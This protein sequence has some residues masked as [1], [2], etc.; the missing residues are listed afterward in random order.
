MC[1]RVDKGALRILLDDHE[2]TSKALLA[3]NDEINIHTQNLTTSGGI[4]SDD[5]T[6]TT[7]DNIAKSPGI[8]GVNSG[9]VT[10]PN[11]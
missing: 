3:K 4:A 2:S 7:S 1:G 8:R 5:T 9:C 6:I 10:P 11:I